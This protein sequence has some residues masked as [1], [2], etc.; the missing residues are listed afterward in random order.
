MMCT[1]ILSRVAA[2]EQ[3]TVAAICASFNVPAWIQEASFQSALLGHLVA[4]NGDTIYVRL[5]HHLCCHIEILAQH[6]LPKY[7]AQLL[8]WSYVVA[9]MLR[10]HSTLRAPQKEQECHTAQWSWRLQAFKPSVCM[11]RPGTGVTAEG[12]SA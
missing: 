1:V 8:L 3:S 7:L 12:A 9:G 2:H 6:R 10:G 4:M 11:G 5:P